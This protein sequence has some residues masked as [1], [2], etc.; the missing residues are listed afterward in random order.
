MQISFDVPNE[1]Q[2]QEAI[3]KSPEIIFKNTRLAMKEAVKQVRD[4]ARV[5]H[6]FRTRS[7]NLVKSIT[8]EVNV[9]GTEVI[10]GRDYLDDNRAY[11]GK[12]VHEGTRPHLIRPRNKKLLRWASG[13]RWHFAKWVNH[14]GTKADQFLYEAGKLQQDKINDIFADYTNRA[15]R[16]AGF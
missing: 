9:G 7:G 3:K 5:R 2:F 11:Y 12:Y 10:E 15:I 4:L 16:E 8:A 6:R 13:G 1:S 14:P